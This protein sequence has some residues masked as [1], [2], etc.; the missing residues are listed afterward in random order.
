MQDNSINIFMKK[1]R[2]GDYS[3]RPFIANKT[4]LFSSEDVQKYA[5]EETEIVDIVWGHA[6]FNWYSLMKKRRPPWINFN[7]CLFRDKNSNSAQTFWK[8]EFYFINIF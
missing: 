4:W 5:Y 7:R 3:V 1:L 2:N 8:Y 6:N